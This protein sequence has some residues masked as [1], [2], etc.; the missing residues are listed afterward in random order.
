MEIVRLSEAGV[1]AAARSAAAVLRA[2]GVVLYPTDTLYGLG[3]D[4]L[5][6]EAVEKVRRIKGREG[7]KPIHCVVADME[8]AEE[9]AELTADARLLAKEFFPGPLTLVLKKKPAMTSGIFRDIPTVGI[10]IP[11]GEFCRALAR[12]FGR[13]YTATSA[14]VSGTESLSIVGGILAQLDD[15][16]RHIDLALDAGELRRREPSTV[17]DTSASQPIVLREGAISAH[18]I[19]TLLR[20]RAAEGSLT[21]G[22]RS[23]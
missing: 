15:N 9:Y 4:A 3:A 6:D 1:E 17:V 14:N 10:R 20:P 12:E 21:A 8:M 2:G 13:P 22:R 23:I 7:K 16:A 5:S 19:F 11:V 18:R